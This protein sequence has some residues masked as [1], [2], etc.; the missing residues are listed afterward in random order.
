MNT[1]IK[2]R[3]LFSQMKA[4]NFSLKMLF[5]KTCWIFCRDDVKEQCNQKNSQHSNS[6]L[7]HLES[8]VD[9]YFRAKGLRDRGEKI[10]DQ[11]RLDC[12]FIQSVAWHGSTHMK[13]IRDFGRLSIFAELSHVVKRIKKIK[14]EEFRTQMTP[15]RFSLA[16]PIDLNIYCW[17]LLTTTTN[18]F[19]WGLKWL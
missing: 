12:V 8:H 18:A 19:D 5:I 10:D 17:S 16:R 13:A 15:S 2:L 7:S 11:G 4:F 6:Y 14:G 9:A 3:G 1:I